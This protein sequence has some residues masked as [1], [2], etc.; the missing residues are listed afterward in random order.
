M[1]YILKIAC[2]KLDDNM[3][4]LVI[5]IRNISPKLS[6]TFTGDVIEKTKAHWKAITLCLYTPTCALKL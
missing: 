6:D 5:L 2:D 3:N 1:F 4:V